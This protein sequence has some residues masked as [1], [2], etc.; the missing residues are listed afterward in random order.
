MSV[1]RRIYS[2]EERSES[3]ISPLWQRVQVVLYMCCILLG[4]VI[5]YCFSRAVVLFQYKCMLFSNILFHKDKFGMNTWN[6]NLAGIYTTRQCDVVIFVPTIILSFSCFF[7]ALFSICGRGGAGSG[8]FKHSW[9]V[10]LPAMLFNFICFFLAYFLNQIFHEGMKYTLENIASSFDLKRKELSIIQNLQVD[11]KQIGLDLYQYLLI[12]K[13]STW[14]FVFLWGMNLFWLL[15]RC[16]YHKDFILVQTNVYMYPKNITM[17][18]TSK[19][20]PSRSMAGGTSSDNEE[21]KNIMQEERVRKFNFNPKTNDSYNKR[22]IHSSTTNINRK[23]NTDQRLIFNNN[24]YKSI[25]LKKNV[26]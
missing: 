22:A 5:S 6:M 10:V 15:L 24:E 2:L 12:T 19:E 8:T 7:M 21:N 25:D 3:E 16:M 26:V 4:F 9:Y 11:G 17:T 18:S 1:Y 13:Y 23:V 14:I 20:K